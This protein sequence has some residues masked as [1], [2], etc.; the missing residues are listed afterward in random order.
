MAPAA[1]RQTTG[2]LSR[3]LMKFDG[4]SGGGALVAS[5]RPG[6]RRST[7]SIITRSSRRARFAPRQKC[8][9]IPNAT[10]SFGVRRT[11]KRN[12]SWNTAASRFGR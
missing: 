3:P 2:R 9:P 5:S 12:G 8:A 4:R 10:C 1:Y 6:R 11:S 7:S